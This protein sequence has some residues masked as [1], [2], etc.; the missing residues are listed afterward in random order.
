MGFKVSGLSNHSPG[1]EVG[2]R[3]TVLESYRRS[4]EGSFSNHLTVP[5]ALKT[6]TARCATEDVPVVASFSDR[7][8]K[9][10]SVASEASSCVVVDIEGS[11]ELATS[12]P[13]VVALDS[14]SPCLLVDLRT[15]SAQ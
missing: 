11:V 14:T 15:F 9:E 7:T 10:D 12:D 1:S 5:S 4:L 8:H 3:G 2:N 13:T 6:C